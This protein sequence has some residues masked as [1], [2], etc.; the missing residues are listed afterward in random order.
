MIRSSVKLL[1][2]IVPLLSREQTNLKARTF[3][4]S[5]A[6]LLTLSLS[7]RSAFFGFQRLCA[8][9]LP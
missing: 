3:Q 7:G 9:L 8:Q 6:V 2:F 1:F 5:R 4:A